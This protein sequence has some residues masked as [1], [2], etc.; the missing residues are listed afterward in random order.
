MENYYC[1]HDDCDIYATYGYDEG[2]NIFCGLHKSNDMVN[3]FKQTQILELDNYEAKTKR[4]CYYIECNIEACYNFPK[5]KKPICCKKH[6]LDG[7]IDIKNKKCLFDNCNK[8]PNYNFEYEKTAIYCAEHKEINMIDITKKLCEFASC[9]KT[10]NFNFEGEKRGIYCSEHKKEGMID[11]KNKRCEFEDCKKIPNYNFEGEKKG[12][13][14]L[15][16]KKFN[17]IDVKSRKCLFKD[18]NKI[19]A[20]NFENQKLPIYCSKHKINGMIDIRNKKCEIEGCS[21]QPNYNY[22]GLKPLYCLSHKKQNMI[23]VLNKRCKNQWCNTRN[24]P[25]YE[26][27]CLRC[28]IHEFPDQ[29]ISRNYKIKERYVTDYLKDQFSNYDII[30]DKTAGGCSKRRADA[31]IDLNTHVI[32]IECD[33]NQH[34]NYDT[35]CELARINELFTDFADR[36]IVFI[37]FN[38][39]KYDDVESSFKYHERTNVPIIRDETEWNCRL[40]KLK[41]TILKYTEIIPDETKF[42]Y[43]FYDS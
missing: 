37:R 2:E 17:M 43:L 7:M 38:P 32:I 29:E 28:F 1:K 3:T 18:C 19:P 22:E 35:T 31:Y 34:K 16:H 39:D 21:K 9:N 24:N 30:F 13:Y 11:I 4:K 36:P 33:E 8:K 40:E 25:K 26:G 10:P 14:C 27:Y 41:E 6:L 20:Y 42:E 23:D 12:I 5:L 15:E